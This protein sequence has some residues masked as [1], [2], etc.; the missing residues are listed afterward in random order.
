MA[1]KTGEKRGSQ[2][3]LQ[4]ESRFGRGASRLFHIL[5][6]FAFAVIL[7]G[8]IFGNQ[9]YGIVAPF[10]VG[11]VL[12]FLAAIWGLTVFLEKHAVFFEKRFCMVLLCAL[13]LI[14]A[15]NVVAGFLLRY[16]P[17]FD[18]GAIFTGAAQ[19]SATGTFL[20]KMNPTC[21][22]AYFYYFPNNLGGMAFLYLPFKLASWFGITD[23]YAIAMVFNGLLATATV[24]LTVLI[25]KTLWGAKAGALVLALFLLSPPTYTI[26]PVFYTDSLSLVFPVLAFYLYLQYRKSAGPRKKLLF[27]ALL[28]ATAAAGMLV[29]FTVV[30]VLIAIVIY[31]L[32]SKGIKS[33]L[34]LAACGGLMAG[35]AFAGLNSYFYAHHLDRDTA[36]QLNTP[37]LHWVMMSLS[38]TGGYNPWDYEFTRSFADAGERDKALRGEIIRR[39]GDLGPRGLAELFYSKAITSFGDGTYAQ[40]DFLDDNPV[41]ESGLHG[42]LLYDGERYDVY[43]HLSGGAFFG[44]Q[45]L[46]LLGAWGAA[47]PKKKGGACFVPHLCVFGVMLFLLF[48]EVS[49]R[50]VTNFIPMMML[51]AASGLNE[52][53]P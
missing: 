10:I 32:C 30:I 23:Y 16:E 44:I 50:Y 20:D 46:M 14:F 51:A 25:G 11:L 26:A 18:L 29:K 31:E 41:R 35:L 21:D 6:C 27:A 37:R 3:P 12:A 40:S 42:I 13:G 33:A 34:A 19:W 28:C 49:G 4:V 5:F 45:A 39:I 22:P 15:A 1:Q 52:K 17:V 2:W 8:V 43:K 7:G 9:R 53:M 38:G 47:L 36:R 48:W 24:L